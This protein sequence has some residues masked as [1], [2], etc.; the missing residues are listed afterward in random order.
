MV[1]DK[2]TLYDSLRRNQLFCPKLKEAIMT[3][4]FMRGCI[5]YRTYWL[6][7]ANEIRLYNCVDPPSRADL[8]RMVTDRMRAEQRTGNEPFDSSF[9]RTAGEI[10]RRPPS[11]EWLL[12]MLGSMEPENGIFAKDYVKPKVNRFADED[13]DMVDN[14]DGWFDGLPVA[15]RN[16][17]KSATVRLG[18][19]AVGERQKLQRMQMQ[20]ESLGARIAAGHA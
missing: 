9:Q 17:K 19:P 5:G 2:D 8:A 18:N 4:T 12:A 16:S 7:K 20:H 10:S 11:Q 6:P 13:P 1:H 14:V 15:A 3:N